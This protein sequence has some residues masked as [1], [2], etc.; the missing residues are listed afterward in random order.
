MNLWM[1]L[2]FKLPHSPFFCHL[3]WLF[4]YTIKWSQVL[5]CLR[6]CSFSSQLISYSWSPICSTP[7]LG[8]VYDNRTLMV[9]SLDLQVN[10]GSIAMFVIWI[11]S[12]PEQ[13][14]INSISYY[15]ACFSFQCFDVHT[16]DYFAYLIVFIFWSVVDTL[17]PPF[18]KTIFLAQYI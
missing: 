5:W 4:R 16:I 1:P 18:T 10:C 12:I 8:S 6:F 2:I 9:T 7:I 13:L 15:F 17:F 11:Q 3:N 14:K